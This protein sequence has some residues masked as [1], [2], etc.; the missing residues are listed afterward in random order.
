[1]VAVSLASVAVI[2][3]SLPYLTVLSL[4]TLGPFTGLE[5]DLSVQ[6]LMYRN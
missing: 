2:P 3:W 1:M 4:T 5:C 6:I